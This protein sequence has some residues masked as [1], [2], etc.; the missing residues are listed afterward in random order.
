MGPS[1]QNL[2]TENNGARAVV[3]SADV[4]AEAAHQVAAH[5]PGLYAHQRTGITFL[6]ARQ[7]AILA[8]DM[9]LGKSRV[10]IIA[11]REACPEGNLLIVCPA[12]VK[13]NWRREIK[14]N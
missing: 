2:E 7:R 5:Y 12:S 3:P 11:L 6:L 8:D 4:L 1:L 9:G 14:L 10:A 13:L